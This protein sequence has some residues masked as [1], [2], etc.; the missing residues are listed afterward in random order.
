MCE[1]LQR[2]PII[3]LGPG[4]ERREFQSNTATTVKDLKKKAAWMFNGDV[5]P[6]FNGKAL[7]DDNALLT[8]YNNSVIHMVLRV[9][10]G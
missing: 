5:Q 1:V 6:T 3:I 2:Q 10:G 4:G 9:H 7:D 8:K